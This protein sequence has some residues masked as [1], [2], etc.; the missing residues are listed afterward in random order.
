MTHYD[1]VVS[2]LDATSFTVHKG[3]VED[4]PTFPYAVLW[5][6]GVGR[7][8]PNSLAVE[9]NR[10]DVNF[11]ITSVGVNNESVRIIAQAMQDAVL[12]QIVTVAGWESYPIRFVGSMPEIQ[13]DRQVSLP[14]S[15]RHPLYTVVTYRLSAERS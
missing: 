14:N 5:W 10:L 3:H 8:S 7:R 12:D 1:E 4:N 15:D 13:E 9:S 6:P 2:L 11:R